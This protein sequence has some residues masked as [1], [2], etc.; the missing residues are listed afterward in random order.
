MTTTE[1]QT[2]VVRRGFTHIPNETIHGRYQS[3]GDAR[4]SIQALGVLTLLLARPAETKDGRPLPQ[5]YRALLGRGMGRDALTK[6]LRE[7][8]EAGHRFRFQRRS[9]ATGQMVTDVV[10]AESPMSP[11]EAADALQALRSRR[12]AREAAQA[13]QARAYGSAGDTDAAAM[14]AAIAELQA[15]L[16][17]MAE[18]DAEGQEDPGHRAP[19]N[20]A[21]AGHR[22]PENGAR[23]RA[24]LPEHGKPSHVLQT[25]GSTHYVRRPGETNAGARENDPQ[26]VPSHPAGRGRNGATMD[27]PG[28]AA[29]RAMRDAAA[30]PVVAPS[31][32][33]SEAEKDAAPPRAF[34]HGVPA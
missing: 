21:R 24:G 10:V 19:E 26:A 11:E 23:P 18:G 14:R 27:G 7:L 20:G 17:A 25:Q 34:G 3:L 32:G 28:Y 16:E 22:A 33:S 29:Y 4:L 31:R 2:Y 8:E 13:A 6:A 15:R 1:G 12:E 30:A 9:K 5:G